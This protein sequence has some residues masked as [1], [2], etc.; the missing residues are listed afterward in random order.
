MDDFGRFDAV[1]RG[2]TNIEKDDVGLHL[3]G[4]FDSLLPIRCLTDD[5]PFLG[6]FLAA[7]GF[8][9]AMAQSHRRQECGID[10]L[11]PSSRPPMPF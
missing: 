8:W 5:A 10:T 6:A 7:N 2:H 9:S 4:F 1:Q 3:N 11:L